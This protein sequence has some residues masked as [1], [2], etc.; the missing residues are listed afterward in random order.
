[1]QATSGWLVSKTHNGVA[2]ATRIYGI[3]SASTP[4]AAYQLSDT[5]NVSILNA[6]AYSSAFNTAFTVDQTEQCATLTQAASTTVT[7][8]AT[9]TLTVQSLGG[10]DNT[11][12]GVLVVNG[13]LAYSQPT[14]APVALNATSGYGETNPN[15][16]FIADTSTFAVGDQ[17]KVRDDSTPAGE[18]KAVTAITTNTYLTVD[19]D[20]AHSYTVADNAAVV[21]TAEREILV[22]TE[23]SPAGTIGGTGT[24][25]GIGSCWPTMWMSSIQA[26]AVLKVIHATVMYDGAG[27]AAGG[28]TGS[29]FGAQAGIDLQ[30][31]MY[32]G[33]NYVGPRRVS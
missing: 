7:V 25:Q 30:L 5:D 4:A 8:N 3:V 10:Q 20:L 16:I 14:A 6:D 12:S 22:N 17:V 18:T 29:K 31:A 13:T 24:I 2:G 9:R 23:A 11:V 15:R 28:V 21:R 33:P 26:G 19:S 27:G 32:A 1:M